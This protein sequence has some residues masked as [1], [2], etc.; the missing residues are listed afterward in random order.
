[1]KN[2]AIIIRGPSGV[3]KSTIA[4]LLHSK[5]KNSADIDIDLL[6]RMISLDSSDARTKIAHSIAQSFLKELISNNFNII[7]EEIFRD[8]QYDEIIEI[9]KDSH[10]NYFTFFL[11]A[12]PEILIQRDKDRKNK[13]KGEEIIYKLFKEIVP[14]KGEAVIDVSTLNNDEIVN[15][16]INKIN[17]I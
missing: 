13:I 8:E 2:I 15:Q 10:Y 14:R 9:L 11:T 3:G 1:M 6:K 17:K 16:I 12:P 7:V 5:I 4:S